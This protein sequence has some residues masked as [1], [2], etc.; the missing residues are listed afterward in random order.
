MYVI[1][2]IGK[3]HQ[4]LNELYTWYF[5]YNSCWRKHLIFLWLL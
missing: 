5:A 2:I 4:L 3:I 1:Y